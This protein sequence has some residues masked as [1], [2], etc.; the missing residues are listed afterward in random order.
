MS[1][2]HGLLRIPESR[3]ELIAKKLM[4]GPSLNDHIVAVLRMLVEMDDLDNRGDPD[5][6][7]TDEWR[8]TAWDNARAVLKLHSDR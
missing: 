6:I 2:D 4:G 8:Q 3:E 7:F 5:K 1:R